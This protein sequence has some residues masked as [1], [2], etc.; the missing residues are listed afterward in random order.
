[1]R[2][3]RSLSL[4]ACLAVSVLVIA[5]E[6][7]AG[8]SSTTPR[9]VVSGPVNVSNDLFAQNEESLGMDPTGTLLAGAWNDWNY[10]DGC[11]FS[12]STNGGSSWAPQT[13]VPGLT[14]FTNNP[15]VPGTG[16]YT[17]AGDPAVAFNP[18]FGVFDV[19][20]QSFGGNPSAVNMLATTFDPS[21]ADPTANVNSS[22]GASAWTSPVSV[23]TGKSN[24]AQKGHNGQFPDHES[25][26]VDT[27][28][29][30]GHHF[31]RIYLTWAQ[32]NGNGRS[33]IQTAFSDDNG[34]TWT[35]PITVSDKSHTT[36]QDGRI[37]IAPNGTLY[38][39]FVGGPNE[40]SLKGNF[41][42]VAKST[43]G[44]LTWGATNE[45]APIVTPIAGLLPNSGYRV[46][47]D[48]T[49]SV[50]QATG[51]LVIAYNDAKSGA[52]QV[53]VVH[54]LTA[55]S[56]AGWSSPMRVKASTKEEFFPWMS[57]APNG[58]V[59]LVYYDRSCDPNDTLNC[60]TL[61]SSSDA[62]ASWGSASLLATGFDG[63]TF[64]AC[65]AFLQPSNCGVVFLGDY[66]AVASTN[67]GAVAMF[68]GNGPSSQD[69]F[70]VGARFPGQ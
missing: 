27:G 12:F 43:D 46:F 4:L 55:G 6:G 32:F 11:G 38:A 7:Y 26:T 44:G 13:F 69:V 19:V 51:Q 8:A 31:G 9:A 67:S 62:G 35:G 10:N 41:V 56:L 28:T 30:P 16:P 57:A 18:R 33:P 64:Q 50:D 47:S 68:T 23:T 5:P 45:V 48:S 22:Y 63:D 49:S 2:P 61:S 53:Y 40:T 15:N 39:T 58:R 21:K 29:G 37:V 60:V 42:A 70:S 65:V 17:A 52:S 25:I 54:Q 20:C 3:L 59:D 14:M 1:M 34:A 24:G 66:I 36:N